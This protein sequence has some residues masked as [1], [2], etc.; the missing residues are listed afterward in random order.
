MTVRDDEVAFARQ[1]EGIGVTLKDGFPFERLDGP[2]VAGLTRAVL[3][4]QTIAAHEARTLFPTQPGGTWAV[5]QDLTSLDD[6]L[7][8]AGVGFGYVWGDLANEILYPF[9]R[10]DDDGQPLT[11]ANRYVLR[12]PP[13]QL[14]PARYWRI[15]MYDIEGFFFHNP[16]TATA[17]AT[18]GTWL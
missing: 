7:Q 5:S 9:A 1:L 14:P 10:V 15:S 16:T 11:G 2:T 8:R 12:F 18:W 4:G 3:D 13:G 6:W 17:S